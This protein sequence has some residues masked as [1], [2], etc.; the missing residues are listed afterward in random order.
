MDLFII[1]GLQVL[2]LVALVMTGNLAELGPWYYASVVVSAM[3]M[4]RHQWLA[5]HRDRE[6]CFAAFRENHVIGMVIF[7]GIMLHYTFTAATS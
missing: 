4:V 1:G 5:R 3:F 7:I 2:M 6:G